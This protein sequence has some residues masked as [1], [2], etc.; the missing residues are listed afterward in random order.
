MM[1]WTRLKSISIRGKS[2]QNGLA[3]ESDP[4][5]QESGE[6]IFYLR[7]QPLASLKNI[8]MT[9]IYEVH[10]FLIK[11]IKKLAK[12]YDCTPCKCA[13]QKLSISND[14]KKAAQKVEQKS[15]AQKSRFKLHRQRTGEPLPT[16][17][18]SPSSIRWLEEAIQAVGMNTHHALCAHVQYSQP[19]SSSQNLESVGV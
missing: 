17:T 19:D 7:K 15:A 11:D 10:G 5:R 8:I 1:N 16:C 3:L 6:I 12:L 2:Y 4:E 9:G 14:M 18:Y 13:S